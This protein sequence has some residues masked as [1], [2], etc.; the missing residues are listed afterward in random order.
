MS[1]L[2]VDDTSRRAAGPDTT[3]DLEAA[4]PSIDE[5]LAIDDPALRALWITQTYAE[6][7]ARLAPTFGPEHTWCSFATWTTTTA[8]AVI[9]CPELPRMVEQLLV[10]S[11]DV[12]GSI[13]D[14]IAA[15]TRFRRRAGLMQPIDRSTVEQLVVDGLHSVAASTERRVTA[16]FARLAPLFERLA[17]TVEPGAPIDDIDA[18]LDAMGLP[19]DD[20]APLLRL[21]FHHYLRAADRSIDPRKRAQFVLTANVAIVVDEQRLA[22]DDIAAAFDPANLDIAAAVEQSLSPRLGPVRRALAR[23]IHDDIDEDVVDVWHHVSTRLLMAIVMPTEVLHVG[24]DVPL[25]DSG[26]RFPPVLEEL[27]HPVLEQLAVEWDPTG[28]DGAAARVDDW[29]DLSARVG[30]LFNLLRA[31]QRDT[32]LDTAAFT[33]GDLAAMRRGEIP[34]LA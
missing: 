32:S 2:L 24:R 28:G 11:E 18:A 34:P 23:S 14:R 7:G 26:D 31:R 27:E 3:S 13:V 15:R 16:T 25:L 8:G 30:Y 19:N 6:L 17:D 20:A 4:S 9:R 10:G 5:I 29:T 33:T 22:D 1:P 12:V 21:A